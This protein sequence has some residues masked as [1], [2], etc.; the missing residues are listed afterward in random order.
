MNLS[1]TRALIQR[2]ESCRLK[3]YLDTKGKITVGWGYN[4]SDR[5]IT[6]QQADVWLEEDVANARR[7]L[8]DL[9]HWFDDLADARQ[10]VLVDIVF[11]AGLD[12]FLRFRHLIAALDVGNFPKAAAEIL[13]SGIA[14]GRKNE[15]AMMMRTGSWT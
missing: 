1:A 11:N 6:Q 9:F 5:G 2:H 3:P 10:A 7:A 15:L 14:L 4:L 8:H 12:G 13:D